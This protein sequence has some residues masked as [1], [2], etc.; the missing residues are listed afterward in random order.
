V[1]GA[2]TNTVFGFLRCS[3]L[4]SVVAAGGVVAGYDA[5]RLALY[6]WVGQGLISVV[7][8]WGWSELADRIRSGEIGSDLLRPVHPVVSYLA[9]DLGRAGFAALTRFV[10]PVAVGVLLFDLYVPRRWWTV[11]LFVASVLLATVTSFCCRFLVNAAAYWLHD[12]RGT[13]MMWTLLAGVMS[14]L[15]FPLRFLPE[16]AAVLLWVAT[17]FPSMLQTPLDVLVEVDAVGRQLALVGIQAGW[18]AGLLALCCAVQRRAEVKL[19]V[20][21]G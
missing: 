19:V 10:V 4:L 18:V 16:W 15:Y 1:A 11:P 9:A 2:F 14:G 5:P 3:V 21:G 7:V 13:I 8:L 12:A 20:Q 6:V 17:P